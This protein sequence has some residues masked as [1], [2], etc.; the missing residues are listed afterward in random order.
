VA[1]QFILLT[2]KQRTPQ[3]FGQ[4]VLGLAQRVAVK[5]HPSLKMSY[6]DTKAQFGGS[7]K[8]HPLHHVG[9]EIRHTIIDGANIN[10]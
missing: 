4:A 6:S 8:N 10:G 3:T 7:P 2:R 9:H 5:S 1:N